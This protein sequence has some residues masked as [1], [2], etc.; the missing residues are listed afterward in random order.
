M[1]FYLFLFRVC[2]HRAFVFVRVFA[3]LVQGGS[4]LE[5]PFAVSGSGS[6]YALGYC[7]DNLRPDL[8]RYYVNQTQKKHFAF[9][10]VLLFL[11][12]KYFCFF[13]VSH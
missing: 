7:D 6:V 9:V 12:Q 11:V 2:V 4:L 8:A 10:F 5:Q 3:F 1:F 13:S